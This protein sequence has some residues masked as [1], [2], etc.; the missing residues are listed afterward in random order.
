VGACGLDSSGPGWQPVV[1]C[2]QYGNEP[3]DSILACQE[4]LCTLNVSSHTAHF[5]QTKLFLTLVSCN[6][7]NETR[8]PSG[9]KGETLRL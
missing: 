2:C 4:G 9:G 3:S 6:I 5:I 7:C 8:L 1:G